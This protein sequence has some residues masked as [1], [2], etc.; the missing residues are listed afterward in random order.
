ME[1]TLQNPI[2]VLHAQLKVESPGKG[3]SRSVIRAWE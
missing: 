2:S 3:V 1:F